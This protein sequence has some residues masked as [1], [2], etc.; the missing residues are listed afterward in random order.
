VK[1]IGDVIVLLSCLF[2]AYVLYSVRRFSVSAYSLPVIEYVQHQRIYLIKQ[3]RLLDT[4]FWWY[5]L[6]FCAGILLPVLYEFGVIETILQKGLLLLFGVVIYI[7]NKR[8]AKS[9]QPLI[10]EIDD[11]LKDAKEAD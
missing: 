10:E 1:Q 5:M 7:L 9:L 3:K 6:P 4:V 8:A 11:F 2:V